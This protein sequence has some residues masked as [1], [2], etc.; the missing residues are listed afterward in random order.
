V[1][2]HT[3]TVQLARQHSAGHYYVF[4]LITPPGHGIPPHVHDREDEMIHVVEGTFLITLGGRQYRAGPG[5]Q[6]FFPRLVAHAFQNIGSSAGR[7]VWTVVPGGNFEDFF[8]Q[9]AGLPPGPPDPQRV[10]A[11]FA[12]FGMTL[13][14]S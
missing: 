13:Q 8:E 6:V 11:I 4:S 10:G 9:L 5:D 2:G 3:A 1:L 14:A 12:A 7:T